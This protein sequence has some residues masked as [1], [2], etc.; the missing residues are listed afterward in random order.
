MAS[1]CTKEVPGWPS[2]IWSCRSRL[3]AQIDAG[4]K[5]DLSTNDWRWLVE[6]ERANRELRRAEGDPEDSLGLLR[7][8][9]RPPITV[10]V[11]FIDEHRQDR[12]RADL[13]GADRRRGPWHGLGDVENRH[14]RM[15]GRVNNRCLLKAIGHIPCRGEANHYRTTTSS[16]SLRTAKPSFTEPGRFRQPMAHG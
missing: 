7:G 11:R 2:P 8:E 10:L 9:T 1:Y 12:G 13:Q 5:P 4:G 15:G 6:L 14:P 16:D 3:Q